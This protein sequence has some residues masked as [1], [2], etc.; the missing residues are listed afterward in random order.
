ME[1]IRGMGE[2]EEQRANEVV[3]RLLW[4]RPEYGSNFLCPLTRL[5]EK[6]ERKPRASCLARG[7]KLSRA[8]SPARF[9]PP[10][11]PA[12]FNSSF[13]HHRPSPSSIMLAARALRSTPRV[14]LVGRSA[15]TLSASHAPSSSVAAPAPVSLSNVRSTLPPPPQNLC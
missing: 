13:P 4:R 1:K 14:V 15:S 7:A 3:P 2:A 6:N 9:A 11:S 12:R 5:R 10:P 8:N